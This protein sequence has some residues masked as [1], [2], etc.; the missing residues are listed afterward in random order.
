MDSGKKH[1]CETQLVSTVQDIAQKLDNKFQTDVIIMDFSKAFYK[2]PH[3]RMLLKL[4]RFRIRNI[5]HAWIKPFLHVTNRKQRVIIDG[6][7]L[8]W[9]DV[10]SSVPQGTVPESLSYNVGLFAD[11]CILYTKITGDEDAARLHEDLN[12]LTQWQSTWQMFNPEKCYV[13]HVT[14]SRSP[15][16]YTRVST[17]RQ[18]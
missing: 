18:R 15:Q 5:T 8:H 11:V 12:R 16:V 1:S 2:V 17:G 6:E 3:Q 4:W 13:L 9:A 7:N 10:E 14:H